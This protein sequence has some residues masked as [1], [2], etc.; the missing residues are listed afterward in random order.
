MYV[1]EITKWI[2]TDEIDNLQ[3][4]SISNQPILRNKK[5]HEIIL[6]YIYYGPYITKRQF[7]PIPPEQ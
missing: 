3:G 2:L 6:E 4:G 5:M 7:V 1:Y